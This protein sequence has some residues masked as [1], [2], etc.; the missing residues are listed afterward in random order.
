MTDVLSFPSSRERDQ[1][2]L[3]GLGNILVSG[4]SLSNRSTD[5][6]LQA[7]Y[8]FML[9]VCPTTSINLLLREAGPVWLTQ[10]LLSLMSPQK[11]GYRKSLSLCFSQAT[12]EAKVVPKAH[13]YYHG[14]DV[15][16]AGPVML[17]HTASSPTFRSLHICQRDPNGAF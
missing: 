2:Q 13:T 10:H 12:T 9:L 11:D 4:I 16:L 15:Y 8:L 7:I 17:S 5:I 6:L 3:A 14:C 1:G